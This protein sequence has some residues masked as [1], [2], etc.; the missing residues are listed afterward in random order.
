VKSFG[1]EKSTAQE[2][3]IQSWNEIRPSVVSASK[4]GAVSPI[5]NAIPTSRFERRAPVRAASV[6]AS[7]RAPIRFFHY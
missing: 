1:C 4:S 5:V 7:T 3:P 6:L 2:S